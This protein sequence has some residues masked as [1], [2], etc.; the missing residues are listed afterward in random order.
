M[1]RDLNN[2]NLEMAENFSR[3][4]N[5]KEFRGKNRIAGSI[6]VCSGRNLQQ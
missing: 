6:R 4:G 2:Y 1:R 3:M 5:R